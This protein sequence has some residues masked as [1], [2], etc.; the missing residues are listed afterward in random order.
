[1]KTQ[2]QRIFSILAILTMAVILTCILVACNG[3]TSSQSHGNSSRFIAEYY[4]NGE[5]WKTSD[6]NEDLDYPIIKGKEL[7]L[8]WYTD[9]L[10]FDSYNKAAFNSSKLYSNIK[11]YGKTVSFSDY[12]MRLSCLQKDGLDV[13]SRFN[14]TA[15]VGDITLELRT[16]YDGNSPL[17]PFPVLT[18]E[19]A[20]G[21][22]IVSTMYYIEDS[23]MVAYYVSLS[24]S[25]FVKA[26]YRVVYD[27]EKNNE[28]EHFCSDFYLVDSSGDTFALTSSVQK[29]IK[30]FALLSCTA[31]HRFATE[32]EQNPSETIYTVASFYENIG[33]IIYFNDGKAEEDQWYELYDT[34]EIYTPPIEDLNKVFEGWYLDSNFKTKFTDID[35]ANAG[36][37]V[38]YAKWTTAD[39]LL[40]EW[41][42]KYAMGK[43]MMLP[44][45]SGKEDAYFTARNGVPYLE[46]EVYGDNEKAGKTAVSYNIKTNSFVMSLYDKNGIKTGSYSANYQISFTDF[47]WKSTVTNENITASTTDARKVLEQSKSA[48]LEKIKN[49][50]KFGHALVMGNRDTSSMG[51]FQLYPL[52]HKIF[53]VTDEAWT[54][55]KANNATYY[56]EGNDLTLASASLSN[57]AFA[58]WYLDKK[59][60]KKV[61]KISSSDDRDLILYPLFYTVSV[62][63]NEN[64]G[65][66]VRI[67]SNLTIGT[68]CTITASANSGY[69]FTG[70]YIGDEKVSDDTSYTF[71]M[72][73]ENKSFVAHFEPNTY[74]VLFDANGG[75]CDESSFA[76]SYNRQYS[77]TLPIP[78]RQ[79][80]DFGGWYY[81][82]AL[83]ASSGTYLYAKDVTLTAK[84]TARADT[85]YIVNH[86][87]Q[88]MTDEYV[89]F[90]TQRLQGRT[91]SN[92]TPSVKRY[93]GFSSPTTKTARIMPDGTTVIDYYYLRNSYTISFVTNGG[94]AIGEITQ[95]F[96]SELA[97]PIAVRDDDTFGGW[98]TSAL[99]DNDFTNTV[100]PANDIVLYAWWAE[101]NKTV[102][103]GYTESDEYVTINS[104]NGTVKNVH[105]P[106]FINDKIVSIVGENAF[107][108]E[109]IVEMVLPSR[110]NSI[111]KEAFY[112]CSAL[113]K[114]TF[115]G[116]E[117]ALLDNYAFAGCS[118]LSKFNSDKEGALVVPSSCSKI[119]S[120]AFNNLVLI[121]DVTVPD[122]VT[123][124]GDGAFS[125]CTALSKF[126]SD[127]ENTIIIPEGVL[128]IGEYAFMNVSGVTNITVADSVTTIRSSAF[129]GC[130]S[131]VSITLPFVGRT[132]T[133]TTS[134]WTVFGY[135]FG[136]TTPENTTMDSSTTI[137]RTSGTE[138][139]TSQIVYSGSS[140]F[141]FT[142][143]QSLRTVTIT[144][145]ANIPAYAFYNCDL[146]ETINLPSTVESIGNYAFYN[147]SAL[148]Q[149]NSSNAN[150][151]NMPTGLLTIGN[152][153]FSNAATTVTTVVVP[154]SVTTIGLGAFKGL[155]SLEKITIPFVGKADD[156]SDI[157]SVFGYIFGYST[158][159]TSSSSTTENKSFIN[160]VYG[161]R[162]S[163]A[164]WQYSMRPNGDF[165][166]YHY[167]I[168]ATLREVTVTLDTTIPVAA[169]NGC[170]LIEKITISDE[171]Y[172]IGA[173]AFQNCK[174]MTRFNSDVEGEFNMPQSVTTINQYAFNNC[175]LATKVTLP[176]NV[177]SIGSYAFYNCDL[178]ETINLPS[179]VE[180]IGNYA[181]YNCSALNQINS[182]NANTLNMPTGLLTIGNYAFSNA[183]T[184]VTTVVVPDS[185]TTIGLG[186]FKGL[187]SLE[188]ITIPFV[189]KADDASDIESVFG[190]IFGYSTTHTSSSSTTENKSF[191][192]QVYGERLSGA[193]WQYSMRPNGDFYS[194]HYYIPATLREVTV[195]LDTTI[196]VAAFN[197]CDLIE[198]I[199]IS[200]EAY[201]IGAYAFQ[202]CKSMTRF[203]SDVEGEF[204]MP[205]SVTTINQYAFN[206]CLLATK[207]TL[208]D[209][210]TSIGSYA[211]Y[212]CSLLSKFNSDKEG[213][214]VVPSSYSNIGSY[215]FSNLVL[216]TDITV[217]D[218]VTTI[219]LGTFKGC[220]G[221]VNITLPFVGA[222]KT[223]SNGYDQVFGYIFGDTT[224]SGSSLV[225]QYSSYYYYIP[226]TIKSVTVTKQTTI[227]QYAF[228]KCDF[229]ESI[230]IPQNV[231]KIGIYAFAEC[232]KLKTLNS[233]IEGEF[234][235]PQSVT[236]INQYA[237]NNCL[238]AAKVTLPD[239]VTSIGSYA[240]YG[241]SLL[242][243][244]NSDKEGSLVVP[245]SCSTIGSYSFNN[246]V[247]ITD[248]TVPDSVTTIGL[249]TFKGCSGLVNITLPFVGAS[250]TAS[251]GYDQVFGYIFGDTTSSGS[252][253][254]NQYSSYY[255]Y[256]P[257]TI[258]SVTVT[259]QTTIPQ[260]AFN[261]CD[262]IESITIPQNVTKIGIYAFAECKKLKTLNSKIEGE[263]N[264]P[265][266][267]TTINQYAFNNCLL[268]TKVTLP[269]NVTSIGDYAFAGCSK[270]SQ[271]NSNNQGELFV[272]KNCERIGAS[273]FAELK[274][275]E[276]VC[277]G[278]IVYRI[279]AAVF[280]KMISLKE[281]ILPFVGSSNVSSKN[282]Y[283]YPLGYVFGT[284]SYTGG[285]ATTQYFYGSSISSVTSENYY[286]PTT[287][288]KVT[289]TL[290]DLNYGAFYNCSNITEVIVSQDAVV[291]EKALYACSA[292]ITRIDYTATN[293]SWNGRDT[294]TAYNSGDGSEAN[295][296]I[297]SNGDEL[298]FFAQQVNNGQSYE[299]VYFKLSQNIYMANKAFEVIGNDTSYFKGVF[300]GNGFAIKSVYITSTAQNVGLFGKTS[301]TIK[302]LSLISTTINSNSTVNQSTAGLLVGHL[303]EGGAVSNCSAQGTITAKCQL[304]LYCGG[305][306]GY[307]DGSVDNSSASVNVS[308][309]STSLMVYAGGLIGYNKGDVINSTAS[310]TVSASGYNAEYTH[311]G[312]IFGFDSKA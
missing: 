79:G 162:L 202:N 89:V 114:V 187:S 164:T 220:S 124:I 222:S 291:N 104:Y 4:V 71:V 233:K 268:A 300:D 144:K 272:P 178:I 87:Q 45:N 173:Y 160:Q 139:L 39:N 108:N 154:D 101:E 32:A 107:K 267:V 52:S 243:K 3:S 117:C 59:H 156:A 294:A 48:A 201:S 212:G 85:Q 66:N 74:N 123:A 284:S 269:D 260:Y 299:G 120:Y 90:E 309:T 225:N 145:Q 19:W 152:Y 259:K 111:L 207:V 40:Q 133:E 41:V 35:Y 174:S 82:N 292:T 226:K 198:K 255:Y 208:P 293:Y 270:I 155:S 286:I 279:G 122:S 161:E 209:N 263:F 69:T 11:Y 221:L 195:T 200:D 115:L 25:S 54:S 250:K 42:L 96:E 234:N 170:D 78:T 99:L 136:D 92:V 304:I 97:L 105:I 303:L 93:V 280:S 185:V 6:K 296:Y 56:L 216:I 12:L 73:E 2:K 288:Q 290:G 137:Y 211:F 16:T 18:C 276:K 64:V 158:T 308:A 188:K 175:L 245:S 34:V 148:N 239:N 166:S 241:C 49:A 179:T 261:K 210:V 159:H 83:F 20:S 53:Y 183:A 28:D 176:D 95:K 70:W 150:T 184:T 199:T 229:I 231:T 55:F 153:A 37:T 15:D 278:D 169:F 192:N 310:G 213:S 256:I 181:F 77:H 113:K 27:P 7:F 149:I 242:S 26:D 67:S 29:V 285:T 138:G 14:L 177:T 118:L 215:A 301:G 289:I 182:S 196:P 143:P 157:E 214:L 8:G 197:G 204:N 236:T 264:I 273:A 102:D 121:T 205:Q 247:L 125:G 171:A 262:F 165:Y 252:S 46:Y 98:F 22:E 61:E 103:F 230:T 65:G 10:Y 189:G 86:W 257:K 141:F 72:S 217:P 281:I 116:N 109:S 57:A 81:S 147:C 112:N 24:N 224:S 91:D 237:F 206:N 44:E 9:E 80:Y 228:N 253:L 190:Y 297:I 271:F 1:M 219:G 134:R 218:S 140:W 298:A 132:E 100:M 249:G 163:G 311:K 106:E 51:N 266:S 63:K 203:N 94:N 295:P 312:N 88:S 17:N 232:K 76:V 47:Q 135:I 142:I 258:K 126:N 13:Y 30:S 119:G 31:L 275:I 33:R 68:E 194:Y 246:L 254:V 251:N 305:L 193:T 5:L 130:N 58:G 248:I 302:N 36:T 131:L 151:L 186:A 128:S 238:L 265:Q 167:Y 223:A 50:Y 60:T 21:G 274:L 180:S 110:I 244:F 307:N 146:I 277:V 227:P 23:K 129:K 62:S 282:T 306:I 191:I 127:D 84:W 287:L 283:Q 43:K 235:I 240:F 168:P 75:E 38:L 172:S